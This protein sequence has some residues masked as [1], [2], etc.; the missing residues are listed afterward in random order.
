MNELI[1]VTTRDHTVLG[2]GVAT[3]LQLQNKGAGGKWSEPGLTGVTVSRTDTG[4]LKMYIEKS[5]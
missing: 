1:G 5:V 2:A 3:S 4:Q